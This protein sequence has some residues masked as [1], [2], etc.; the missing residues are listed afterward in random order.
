MLRTLAAAAVF[1]LS[2]MAPAFAGSVDAL[3]SDNG[4]RDA[5]FG[6]RVESFEGLELL[7]SAD[8]A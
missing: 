2:A 5:H 3:D 7:R 1:W 8:I 4:F 6:A